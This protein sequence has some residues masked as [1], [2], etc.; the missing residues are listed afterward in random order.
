MRINN[1]RKETSCF[2]VRDLSLDS[3]GNFS[4]L[5]FTLIMSLI[6]GSSIGDCTSN[7]L[8]LL[9]NSKQKF[10]QLLCPLA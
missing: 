2:Y 7:S 5:S 3:I 6:G 8:F 4:E 1:K 10:S 9:L